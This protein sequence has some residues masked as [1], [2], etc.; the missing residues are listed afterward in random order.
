MKYYS[1]IGQD[2]YFIENVSKGKRNGIFLDIG[3]NNGIFESNTAALEFDYAWSGICVEANP[4]LI[5]DL[6]NNRPNSK[7]VNCAVWNE[8]T[9]VELE[10]SKSNH[11]GI[12]GDLLSRIS[13][14][15]RNKK[16]FEKHFNEDRNVIKVAAEPVTTIIKEF[17][18]LPCD[19]DYMSLDVEG[20]EIEALKG[21][22]FSLINIKFMTIEHGNRP[23]Y[24]DQ[25]VE[26]LAPHGYKIHRI[27]RWDVEFVR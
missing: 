14:L 26:C 8:S 6:K 11:K 24:I 21:I 13:N 4:S 1:Q 2:Q 25:F 27:N 19:I 17:Y 12:K 7:I 23:G 16:Y 3:A 18:N 10:I 5:Q 20:A 22:D 15:E 9:K